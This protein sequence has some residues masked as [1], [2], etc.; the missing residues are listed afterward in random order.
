MDQ[1]FKFS[2]TWDE[3]RPIRP[4][5]FTMLAIQILGSCIS[6]AIFGFDRFFEALWLGGA[7]ATLPGFLAGL[8]VQRH[9]RPGS[10]SG[11]RQMVILLGLIAAFLTA[12]AIF[13]PPAVTAA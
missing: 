6:L 11:N 8:P 1:P 3:M 2:Y 10:L 4:L 12:F 13:F 9:L 5:Y 7:L